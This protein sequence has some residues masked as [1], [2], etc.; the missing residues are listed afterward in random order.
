M[1]GRTTPGGGHRVRQAPENTSQ[2]GALSEGI[3]RQKPWVR[4]FAV[5]RRT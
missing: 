5:Q 1:V 2:A 3:A 4:L